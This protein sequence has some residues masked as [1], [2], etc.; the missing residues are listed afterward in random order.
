MTETL[1]NSG[2][3]VATLVAAG[4]FEIGIQPVPDPGPGEVLIRVGECGVCGSDVKMYSG[5][6]PVH[7]PPLRLGHE[8]IGT[9]AGTGAGVDEGRLGSEVA[10]YPGIGCG[11]CYSCRHGRPQLC[12]TMSLVGGHLPGG[13]SDHLVVP[14]E[15]AVPLDPAIPAGQEVLVEP[16]AVALHAV[17]RGDLGAG[18]SVLVIGAGPIGLFVA[19]VLRA[20]GHE[21]ILVSDVLERRREA[22]RS[23]GFEEIIDP[24]DGGLA[25]ALHAAGHPDGVDVAFECAGTAAAVADGLEATVPGGRVVLVGVTPNPLEVD[26]VALQRRERSLIGAMMYDPEE[27]HDAMRI[28]AGGAIDGSPSADGNSLTERFPLEEIAGAFR[29]V[30]GHNEGA[31]KLVAALDV[32]R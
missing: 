5:N 21:G 6:H 22:A 14:A 4:E 19:H 25:E 8:V 23:C 27:F 9:I 31:V 11:E 15:N 18:E 2:S 1:P 29:A 20:R 26:S 32:E 13:F 24:E 12:D 28:L 7:R 17:N 16:F 10:V 30:S 3:R